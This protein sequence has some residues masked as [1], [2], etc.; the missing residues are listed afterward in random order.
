[1][2]ETLSPWMKPRTEKLIVLLRTLG[3]EVTIYS[4][5]RTLAQQKEKVRLGHSQTLNSKHLTGDAADL[6]ITHRA[7]YKFAGA[8]WTALGGKWGGDFR[9]P[10]LAHQEYQHFQKP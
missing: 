2:I 4:A 3:F 8:V 1:M 10:T 7:I 9:D 6:I 5:R